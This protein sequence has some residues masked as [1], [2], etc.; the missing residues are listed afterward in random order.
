MHLLNVA[1]TSLLFSSRVL[2]WQSHF[3]REIKLIVCL[4]NLH[5]HLI[6]KSTMGCLGMPLVWCLDVVV[7]IVYTNIVIVSTNLQ[8]LTFCV[9]GF[10]LLGPTE[11]GKGVFSRTTFDLPISEV[12]RPLQILVSI[13]YSILLYDI[14][15]PDWEYQIAGPGSSSIEK[16]FSIS[17]NCRCILLYLSPH[18][19]S[20]QDRRS[21]NVHAAFG[22]VR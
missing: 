22:Y 16:S 18:K 21:A 1:G 11:A 15:V 5:E 9:L 12:S 13:A 14:Y 8:F 10:P 2:V 6:M 17:A 3:T 7:R 19:F 20:T 4:G